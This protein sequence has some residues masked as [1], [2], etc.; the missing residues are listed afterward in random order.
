MNSLADS[1]MVS[2]VDWLHAPEPWVIFLVIVPGV[3]LLTWWLYRRETARFSG[4][5]RWPLVLLRVAT[6]LLLIGFLFEPMY[7][8]ERVKTENSYLIVLVDQSYSMSI[9]DQYED[10]EF[11]NA[12]A[13]IAGPSFD[14]DSTRL[15]LMRSILS[16]SELDLITELRKKANVRLVGFAK[17]L[18]PIADLPRLEDGEVANPGDFD[19]SKLEA[20][21]TV[22]EIGESLYESVNELRGEKISGVLLLSDGRDTGAK[23]TPEKAADR[24]ARRKIPIYS[25]GIGDAEEPKDIRVYGLDVAEVVLENDR[26]PIDFTVVSKGYAG[27]MPVEIKLIREGQTD[28]PAIQKY[29]RLEDSEDPQVQRIDFSPRSRGKYTLRV[30]IPEQEGERIAINNFDEGPIEVIADKIKLLYIEGPPR[31]EYRYLK[32]ALIRDPTMETQV[33]LTSADDEYLQPSSPGIRPLSTFPRS[34][35]ELFKYHL[36][37][38]GDVNPDFFS[39]DQ[40]KWLVE[41]VDDIG[42]G[43]AF[44]AGTWFMPHKYQGDKTLKDL[45]P[46]S[47]EEQVSFYDEGAF[48]NEFWVKLTPEGEEH[49]TMQFVPNQKRNRDHWERRGSL[50]VRLPGFYWFRKVKSLKPGAVSLANHET[51][52]HPSK[53]PRPIFVAQQFGRGRTFIALTD[54]TW[55]WRKGMGNFYFYRFWAQVFRYTSAGRLQAKKQRF[56]VST[57]AK[58][59]VLE[60]KVN[61]LVRVLDDKFKA[62]QDNDPLDENPLEY[63]VFIQRVDPPDETRRELTSSQVLARP[64]FFEAVLDADTLGTFKIWIEYRGEEVATNSFRVVVPQLE[65]R[66][67]RMDRPRLRD[68]AQRSG[69]KFFEINQLG[70][71]PNEVEAYEKEIAVPAESRSLWDTDALLMLIVGLLTAEWILR[72]LLRLV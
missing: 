14:S 7:V 33:L 15:D 67:P 41:F 24:L 1:Q 23:L 16:N 40:K 68:L 3:L 53:G 72:K 58:E 52:R 35:E 27:R 9:A 71:I 17:E 44:I 21:G 18:R 48:Q 57:D 59:Y 45:F 30:E 26:V 69:G 61:V 11:K 10:P 56:A 37:L 12:I 60:T 42:G 13:E 55:R 6:V 34:R 32:H 39:E 66:E 8:R 65:Y 62:L 64:E 43:V 51:E 28:A 31:Y 29:I 20:T 2:R 25:V 70:D 54:E 63:P 22:T 49:P 5:R 4:W 50:S 47:L 46:V 36:V 19:L 38:I